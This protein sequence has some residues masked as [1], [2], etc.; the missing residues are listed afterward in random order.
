MTKPYRTNYLNEADLKIFKVEY[1]INR[2][3]D[4]TQILNLSLHD[5]TIFCRSSY[6]RQPQN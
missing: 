6:G 5:Q 4:R 3:L 1:L 2:L